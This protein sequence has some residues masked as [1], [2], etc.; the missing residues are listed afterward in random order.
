M[1]TSQACS[2]ANPPPIP[3]AES[4]L[5]KYCEQVENQL[6]ERFFYSERHDDTVTMSTLA[7][8]LVAM[9]GGRSVIRRYIATRP[10]FMH[11]RSHDDSPSPLNS[12][13]PPKSYSDASAQAAASVRALALTFD[14]IVESVKSEAERIK[15]VFPN[16]GDVLSLL[17][18]RV[19]E[20]RVE[21]VLE[22]RVPQIP[23]QAKGTR[24]DTLLHFSS[25]SEIFHPISS[26]NVAFRGLIS[27]CR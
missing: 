15:Q 18:Q 21:E 13:H 1:P 10:M 9:N 11:I 2:N 20:Q 26:V 23:S 19:M 14:E 12:S 17:V 4:N 22:F 5:E 16:P 27:V 3:S 25:L 6:L 8:A 24:Q 7:D